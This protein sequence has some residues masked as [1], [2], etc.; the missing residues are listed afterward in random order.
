M[1]LLMNFFVL[2]PTMR[3]LNKFVVKDIQAYWED[4]AYAL[5]YKPAIV[6]SI[7][8]KHKGDPKKCCQELL[9]S[10]LT[11]NHGESQRIWSVLLKRID[12]VS[13][14]ATVCKTVLDKLIKEKLTSN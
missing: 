5:D 11:I 3:E 9:K 1:L 13:E 7:N 4:V 12:E 14:L 8:A 6:D 10:W 2:E